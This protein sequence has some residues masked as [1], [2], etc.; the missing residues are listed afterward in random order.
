MNSILRECRGIEVALNLAR[1]PVVGPIMCQFGRWVDF[2]V[3]FECS[4][5]LW[6]LRFIGCFQH[7][8]NCGNCIFFILCLNACWS[9]R[10]S[11]FRWMGDDNGQY[12]EMYFWCIRRYGSRRVDCLDTTER[13]E[14]SWQFC[15]QKHSRTSSPIHRKSLILKSLPCSEDVSFSVL[16]NLPFSKIF[17]SSILECLPFFALESISFS[18]TW[19]RHWAARMWLFSRTD[20]AVLKLVGTIKRCDDIGATQLGAYPWTNSSISPYRFPSA[21]NEFSCMRMYSLSAKGPQMFEI[22]RIL[23]IPI[24]TYNGKIE[25]RSNLGDSINPPASGGVGPKRL[26]ARSSNR[27]T[28]FSF[29]GPISRTIRSVGRNCSGFF[30]GAQDRSPRWRLCRT[31]RDT[32]APNTEH[33]WH[34]RKGPLG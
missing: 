18:N 10:R 20:H 2:V 24:F 22:L 13:N 7:S 17:H 26:P 33:Q 32:F 29:S 31:S 9:D 14:S 3:P 11:R 8:H 4:T 25:S 19:C 23:K 21:S 1:F 30:F 34:P 15:P 16:K 28:P 12:L 5:A 6:V 27:E